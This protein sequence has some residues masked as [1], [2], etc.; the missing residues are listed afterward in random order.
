MRSAASLLRFS[1][2]APA[3]GLDAAE[4]ERPLVVSI[5]PTAIVDHLCVIRDEAELK[6][7]VPDEIGAELPPSCLSSGMGRHVA[8]VVS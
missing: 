6:A 4:Q 2:P 3:A 8:V 5:Q 7:L 1:P